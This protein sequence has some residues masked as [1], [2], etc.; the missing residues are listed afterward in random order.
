M[1]A[2]FFLYSLLGLGIVF[3]IVEVLILGYTILSFFLRRND[4]W[5]DENFLAIP[6]L[7]PL[8]NFFLVLICAAINAVSAVWIPSWL[9]NILWICVIVNMAVLG[10]YVIGFVVFASVHISIELTQWTIE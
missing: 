6:V 4:E 3:S 9:E 8:L 7:L 10:I 5:L 2:A 1:V